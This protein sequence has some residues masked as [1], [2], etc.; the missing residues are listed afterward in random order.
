MKYSFNYPKPFV[1]ELQALPLLPEVQNGLPLGVQLGL[2]P[3][4]LERQ[5]RPLNLGQLELVLPRAVGLFLLNF[6]VFVV[7][8]EI[9]NFIAAGAEAQ[10]RVSTA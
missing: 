2:E 9:N 5:P 4:A 3:V 6:V 7:A 8:N 1:A 10:A